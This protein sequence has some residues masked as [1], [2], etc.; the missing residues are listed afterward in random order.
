MPEPKVILNTL[1]VEIG[2]IKLDIKPHVPKEVE[3]VETPHP[4]A[5]CAPK[6]GERA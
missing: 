4:D 1:G 6:A 3:G 2:P 5:S